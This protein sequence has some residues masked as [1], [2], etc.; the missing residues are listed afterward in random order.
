MF[1]GMLVI[2]FQIAALF[3]EEEFRAVH[4]KNKLDDEKALGS[5]KNYVEQFLHYFDQLP[6]NRGL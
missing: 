1:V 3:R 4:S 2:S 6:C 5:F